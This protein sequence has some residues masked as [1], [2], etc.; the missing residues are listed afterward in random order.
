MTNVNERYPLHRQHSKYGSVDKKDNNQGYIIQVRDLTDSMPISYKNIANISSDISNIIV[1]FLED[2]D[3]PNC[4]RS[5][6]HVQQFIISNLISTLDDVDS[7]SLYNTAKDKNINTLNIESLPIIFYVALNSRNHQNY[8]HIKVLFKSLM[9]DF[10]LEE[11]RLYNNIIL[12]LKNIGLYFSTWLKLSRHKIKVVRPVFL[13]DVKLINKM[14]T[15]CEKHNQIDELRNK[16][17]D[18]SYDIFMDYTCWSCA[19]W[20]R[21]LMLITVIILIIWYCLNK[22]INSKSAILMLTI[23]SLFATVFQYINHKYKKQ[24]QKYTQ[25]EHQTIKYFNMCIL[26]DE[27]DSYINGNDVYRP[28]IAIIENIASVE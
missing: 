25:E 10:K 28:K 3:L 18:G 26:L 11:D 24:E 9:T 17:K 1:G 13:Q 7:R 8:T 6:K 22:D 16:I 23:C 27:E 15:L 2:K 20:T 12:N 14:L 5:T 19:K 4:I 21:N